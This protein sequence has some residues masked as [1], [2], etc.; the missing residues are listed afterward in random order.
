MEHLTAPE[1]GVRYFMPT[2]EAGVNEAAPEA[3]NAYSDGSLKNVKGYFW[4]VG[5]AGIWWPGRAATTL[6]AAEKQAAEFREVEAPRTS[7]ILPCR[8]SVGA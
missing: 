6:T 3:I 7:S 8:N 1:V 4:G 5:G 2:I